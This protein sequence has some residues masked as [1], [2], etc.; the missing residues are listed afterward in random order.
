MQNMDRMGGFRKAMPFTFVTF[1]IGALALAGFP[2]LSGWFSKDE[3]IGFDVHRGGYDLVLAIVAFARRA[4][5]RL[6][7]VPD[8]LPRLLRRRRARGRVDS[9]RATWPTAST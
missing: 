2:P 7:L 6:L 8:G 1:T 3:I 4:A 9:S 5:H